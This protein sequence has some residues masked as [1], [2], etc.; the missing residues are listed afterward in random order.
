MGRKGSEDM[1]AISIRRANRED[2]AVIHTLL[3]E[4]EDALGA[5]R[6]VRRS[7]EDICRYG[8]GESPH[9]ETQL[10]WS[11]N[12][13]VG[14]A[15]YFREFS[16]W[17]GSPGVYVQDLYVSVKLR[18]CGLGRELMEAVFNR[19]RCWGATYCKLA[20]YDNNL[21]AEN[22]Y[23]RMGFRVSVNERV[24]LLDELL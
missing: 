17:R 10:A 7:E 16:T 18:G 6:A 14:L 15:V 12:E 24:F 13:A 23:Q 3:C 19:A 22:F 2:A 1:N 20:V 21:S 5:G 9:F 4:L 11:G 8:F